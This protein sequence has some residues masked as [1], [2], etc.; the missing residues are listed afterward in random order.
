[1]HYEYDYCELLLGGGESNGADAGLSWL[2]KSLPV[3]CAMREMVD[4]DG[5][6]AVD[7]IIW[8]LGQR[9]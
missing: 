4:G 8:Q 2:M 5:G 1:M 3:L 7:S 9:L 6:T